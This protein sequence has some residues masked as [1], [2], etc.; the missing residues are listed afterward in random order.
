MSVEV[1]V[2]EAVATVTIDRPEVLNAIDPPTRTEL[3]EIFTELDH[4]PRVRVIVL[5]G[6][7]ERSF[8]AGAD[9][10]AGTPVGLEYWVQERPHGFGAI[11]HRPQLLKPV[12]ARVNGLALGGGFEMVL[13]C[14]IVIAAEHAVF[15][16]PEPLVGGLPLDAG[17]PLLARAVPRKIANDL[18]LTGRRIAADEAASWGLVNEVV[19]AAELDEAVQRWVGRLTRPAPL[20]Q[21]AIKEQLVLAYN[22]PV[23]A[24]LRYGGPATM[25]ALRSPD[26]D[27]G[28]AAF[29]EK[30][31]P[32]WT[33][34]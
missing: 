8:C 16:L 32:Q 24:V 20:S 12:L 18:L 10:K 31:A 13:G 27:E 25:R 34:G 5:T 22:Q 17:I 21:R 4:D 26:A 28:A 11:S 23:E 30:R 3:E 33:G 14:D 19:P 2:E 7:G 9:L 6:A 29:R 15:G 1:R